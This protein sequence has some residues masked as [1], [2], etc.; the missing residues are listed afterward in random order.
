MEQA[1]HTQREDSDRNVRFGLPESEEEPARIGRGVSFQEPAPTSPV[2]VGSGGRVSWVRERY[3]RLFPHVPAQPSLLYHLGRSESSTRSVLA[4]SVAVEVAEEETKAAGAEDHR[5]PAPAVGTG[6]GKGEDGEEGE[7]MEMEIGPV[8][9]VSVSCRVCVHCVRF[10]CAHVLTD[11]NPQPQLQPQPQLNQAL[12]RR[13]SGLTTEQEQRQR[14]RLHP[15]PLALGESSSSFLS[16]VGDGGLDTPPLSPPKGVR[17]AEPAEEPAEEEDEEEMEPDSDEEEYGDEDDEGEDDD[18]DEGGE[19]GGEGEEAQA[20]AGL[21]S[22]SSPLVV[23][24]VVDEED[25]AVAGSASE[26]D[27]GGAGG[28]KARQWFRQSLRGMQNW[29][30]TSALAPG[31][32]GAGQRAGSSSRA[33]RGKKKRRKG[34]RRQGQGQQPQVAGA[35]G[36]ARRVGHVP[37]LSDI[38]E[39][40]AEEADGPSSA[41]STGSGNSVYV[42]KRGGSGKKRPHSTSSSGK[43][44]LVVDAFAFVR[45]GP[46]RIAGLVT[47]TCQPYTTGSSSSANDVFVS[48]SSSTSAP[49]P[50]SNRSLVRTRMFK[51]NNVCLFGSL[52]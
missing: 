14:R 40:S 43:A 35:G 30:S 23:V 3:L 42:P 50:G 36:P 18:S 17:K 2:A 39:A 5:Q 26:T 21:D 13:W 49:A 19:D 29:L 37:G 15:H 28:T 34:S 8:G 51:T 52:S 33:R 41:T 25:A 38:T 1:A 4:G 46:T 7:N 20:G 44:G 10:C 48:G 11:P 16:S 27:D 6:A 45:W 31:G 9:L 47:H 12:H 22:S 24:P 32:S